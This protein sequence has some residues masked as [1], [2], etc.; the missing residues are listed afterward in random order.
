M[1]KLE[2]KQADEKQRHSAV[3]QKLDIGEVFETKSGEVGIKVTL[4]SR[5]ANAVQLLDA[6]VGQVKLMTLD[7]DLVVYPVKS[8]KLVVERY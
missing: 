3:F 8:A 2:C 4:N 7:D 1:A 5:L 6:D